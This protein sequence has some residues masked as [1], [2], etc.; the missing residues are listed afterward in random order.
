MLKRCDI[1]VVQGVP[2]HLAQ[3][4]RLSVFLNVTTLRATVFTRFANVNPQPP[5]TLSA[6]LTSSV[7]GPRSD[8]IDRIDLVCVG[9]L[10]A[11]PTRP[12]L[13]LTLAFARRIL[14]SAGNL[15]IR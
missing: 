13:S 5:T 10:S 4:G 7:A 12:T 2:S 15:S 14:T 9:N 3:S 6:S 8:A 11:Y 1:N